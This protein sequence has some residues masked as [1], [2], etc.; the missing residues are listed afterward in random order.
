MQPAL[1]SNPIDVTNRLADLGVTRELLL[2]VVDA[3]VGARNSCTLNDPPGT[4]GW[5]S[6][7]QGTRRLRELCGLLGMDR[8]DSDQIS[9]VWDKASN[10]RIAISNTDDGTG[11]LERL[12][13]N[14]SKKGAATNRLVNE[15]YG[16]FNS[17]MQQATNVVSM[18]TDNP[19]GAVLW[20][21]CVYAEGD[22][23]RAELSCPT[24]CDGGYFADFSER[25]FIIGPDDQDEFAKRHQSGGGDGEDFDIQITRK[26]P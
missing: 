21:L 24:N 18:S 14:R 25:I 26:L 20:Y 7:Q 12:P 16:A 13:M 10:I 5:R 22:I 1:F 9:C 4:P 2:E 3:C 17:L 11:M 23:V 19:S 6:W 15:N 8:D